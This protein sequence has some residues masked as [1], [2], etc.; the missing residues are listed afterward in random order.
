M[1]YTTKFLCFSYCV[2][3]QGGYANYDQHGLGPG[4]TIQQSLLLLSLVEFLSNIVG[5]NVEF[6]L[7][8]GSNSSGELLFNALLISGDNAE[9]FQFLEGESDDL[10]S[11]GLMVASSDSESLVSTVNVLQ[12][13]DTDVNS[14]INLSGDGSDSG[15]EP[16]RIFGGKVFEFGSLDMIDPSRELDFIIL[17]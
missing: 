8:L 14:K 6:F 12:G 10:T 9:F 16:I 15:V 2:F 17:F 3:G 1:S 5:D 7:S 4:N 11:S 13:A